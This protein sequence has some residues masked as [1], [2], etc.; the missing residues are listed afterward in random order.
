MMD[1]QHDH[2][3]R[4]HMQRQGT[5]AMH[6]G[7]LGQQQHLSMASASASTVLLKSGHFYEEHVKDGKRAAFKNHSGIVS[8]PKHFGN[9][10]SNFV[11][12]ADMDKH[13]YP[14]PQ[15]FHQKNNERKADHEQMRKSFN[16]YDAVKNEEQNAQPK[17]SSK[18]MA[19][20]QLGKRLAPHQQQPSV[21]N[22]NSQEFHTIF[23]GSKFSNQQPSG[24]NSGQHNL[25]QGGLSSSTQFIF[26]QNA[27]D[28]GQGPCQSKY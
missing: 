8:K 3:N 18:M 15:P 7:G 13:E 5:L 28:G 26:R 22:K 9:Y 21:V 6:G 19:D 20:G 17:Q 23:N 16:T 4:L 24:S 11:T 12:A 1:N 10:G 25:R 14:Q 2:G 27:M